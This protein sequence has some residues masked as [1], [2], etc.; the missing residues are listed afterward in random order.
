MPLKHTTGVEVLLHSFLTWAVD[1][2][3]YPLNRRL[4]GSRPSLEILEGRKSSCPS[5]DLN[6]GSPSLQSSDYAVCAIT[7]SFQHN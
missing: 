3:Q 1:E 4:H 5:Q 7:A 6:L 2:P